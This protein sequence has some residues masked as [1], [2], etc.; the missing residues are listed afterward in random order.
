MPFHIGGCVHQDY[1]IREQRKFMLEERLEIYITVKSIMM[2]GESV[3]QCGS[4]LVLNIT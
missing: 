2:P 3:P 4:I 1:I